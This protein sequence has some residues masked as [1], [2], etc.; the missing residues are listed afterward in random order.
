MN[1]EGDTCANY[2]AFGYD[3]DGRIA[4]LSAFLFGPD[5]VPPFTVHLAQ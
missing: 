5:W 1:R 2:N 3:P 4:W